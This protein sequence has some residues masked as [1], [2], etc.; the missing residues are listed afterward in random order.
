MVE[1]RMAS[2]ETRLSLQIRAIPGWDIE[3]F[4]AYLSD[5]LG[6]RLFSDI[7]LTTSGNGYIVIATE[8]VLEAVSAEAE[9]LRGFENPSYR[10][11]TSIPSLSQFEVLL[12]RLGIA[13]TIVPVENQ[14]MI[15]GSRENV[16]EAS[17]L[18]RQ[19]SSGF[20]CRGRF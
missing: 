1:S 11:E 15:I 13:A 9:K 12:Q 6:P 17:R 10:L 2:Q 8:S 16:E 4:R 14:F 18:V 3:K 19:L 20:L 7:T 5:F